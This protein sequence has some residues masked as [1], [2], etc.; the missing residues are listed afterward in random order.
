MRAIFANMFQ[1]GK[2][3]IS[4]EVLEEEFVCNL[5]ACRG[6]CCVEGD[7]GAPLDEEEVAKVEQNLDAIKPFLRKEGV[8]VIEKQG[9]WYTD[10]DNE[11][12]TSLVDHKECVFVTYDAQGITKCGM[13]EAYLE[14]KTDFKKPISCHLYPIRLKQYQNF[15]AV[16]Y[17]R[18]QICEAAC[19]HGKELNVAV[20]KFLKEPLIRKFGE[21][22]YNELALV[23]ENW[24]A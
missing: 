9:F 3:L 8:E 17:H 2:T 11:K 19:F 7:G 15:V 1:V 20:Y 13:E 6:A 24:K 22:W 10:E 18:W 16:N 5:S 14:G 12:L 23:A 4:E 21:D